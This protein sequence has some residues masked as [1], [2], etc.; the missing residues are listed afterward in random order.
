[1]FFLVLPSGRG[2]CFVDIFNQNARLETTH[3]AHKKAEAHMKPE[4]KDSAPQP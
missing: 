4:S 3:Q 1:M 2:T